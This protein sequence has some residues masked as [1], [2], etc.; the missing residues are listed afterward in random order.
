VK[1]LNSVSLTVS[2]ASS[3]IG[4]ASCRERVCQ[5][6][7]LVVV[8]FDLRLPFPAEVE[9][10]AGVGFAAVP[11]VVRDPAVEVLLDAVAQLLARDCDR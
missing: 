9:L 8:V 1:S 4:R 3:K 10:A 7:V 2:A 6:E 11:D 5:Y